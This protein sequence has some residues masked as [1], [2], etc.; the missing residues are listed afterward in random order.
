MTDRAEKLSALPYDELVRVV[1]LEKMFAAS[2]IVAKAAAFAGVKMEQWEPQFRTWEALHREIW[3]QSL[4]QCRLGAPAYPVTDVVK[5]IVSHMWAF[6][7]R[8]QKEIQS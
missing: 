8:Y 4:H 1:G 5:A 7:L 2:A 3:K 6:G